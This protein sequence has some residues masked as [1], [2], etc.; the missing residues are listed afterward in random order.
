MIGNEATPE[1]K[2]HPPPGEKV[3]RKSRKPWGSLWGALT[4]S[5]LHLRKILL[6]VTMLTVLSWGREQ[7]E[8]D[9]QEGGEEIAV[10]QERNYLILSELYLHLIFLHLL[11]LFSPL[12]FSL[13]LFFFFPGMSHH[14]KASLEQSALWILMAFF[15]DYKINKYSW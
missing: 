7:G 1:H 3:K 13:S 12:V 10:G 9:R 14:G 5:D 8:T 11:I 2:G 6:T 15:S 4:R